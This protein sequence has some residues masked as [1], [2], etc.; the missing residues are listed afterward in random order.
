MILEAEISNL[1][2]TEKNEIKNYI[3]SNF[4]LPYRPSKEKLYFF[5]KTIKK[6]IMKK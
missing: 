6:I 2:K 1:S 5:Y 3:L 4:S